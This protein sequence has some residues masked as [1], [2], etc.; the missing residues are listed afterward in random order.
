LEADLSH[1]Q[2]IDVNQ[3]TA[4]DR[5]VFGAT[6]ELINVDTDQKVRYQI[7]GEGEAD[8]KQA[9]YPIIRRSR[10]SYWQ[11]PRY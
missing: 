1:S 11:A 7:V 4:D 8:L 6:V 9:R 2:V 3:F 5:V 10:A